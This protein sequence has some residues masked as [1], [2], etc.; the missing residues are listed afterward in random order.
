MTNTTAPIG[1]SAPTGSATVLPTGPTRVGA[2]SATRL[3][4]ALSLSSGNRITFGAGKLKV[5]PKPIYEVLT[6]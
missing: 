3:P 1:Q 5:H 6:K 4:V 2:C